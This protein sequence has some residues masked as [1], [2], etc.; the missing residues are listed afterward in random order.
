MRSINL[1]FSAGR[2]KNLNTYCKLAYYSYAIFFI[3]FI[4]PQ[5]VSYYYLYLFAMN[6]L[7]I[8]NYCARTDEKQCV[9]QRKVNL[10]IVQH[11][12]FCR[13]SDKWVWTVSS[14]EDKRRRLLTKIHFYM[15]P[16]DSIS[17]SVHRSVHL[18]II[19]EKKLNF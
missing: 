7:R 1:E 11:K 15:Q 3:S 17:L 2:H 8:G 14:L 13:N 9:E 16:A 5:F 19:F 6:I 10:L 4:L 18:S 12:S